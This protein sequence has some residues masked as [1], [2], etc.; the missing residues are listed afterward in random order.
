M[1]SYKCDNC[2][3]TATSLGDW[4]IVQI[5]LLHN[6]PKMP[7]PPGGITVDMTYPYLIFDTKQCRDTWLER[8]GLPKGPP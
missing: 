3:V 7:T 2:E 6:D 5:Q 1:I 8:A 4:E